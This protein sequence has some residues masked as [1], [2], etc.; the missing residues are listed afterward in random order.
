MQ[1]YGQR[2]RQRPFFASLLTVSSHPPFIDPERHQR[3]EE[4]VIRYVDREL[5]RFHRQLEAAGF[6]ANGLLLITGDHRAMTPVS[7][8]EARDHGERALSRVPLIV[9]GRSALAPGRHDVMAQQA[10]LVDSLGVLLGDEYCRDP[11]R[12]VF[13]ASPPAEPRFVIHVRGDRRSWLSVYTAQGD[14]I[15]RL[16]GDRTGWLGAPPAGGD[17]I[18]HHVNGGRIRLGQAQQDAVDYMIRQRSAAPGN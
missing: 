6:F 11:D 16:D 3:G 7:A 2:D 18:V 4:N 17:A 5:G 8:A 10:D 14:A 15:L 12:G 1:W 9:A 13:L